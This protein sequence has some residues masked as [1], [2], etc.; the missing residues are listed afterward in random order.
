MV[1]LTDNRDLTIPVYHGRKA[2]EQDNQMCRS[3]H[4]EEESKS[5][6]A[7][8]Y[9]GKKCCCTNLSNI[10]VSSDFTVYIFMH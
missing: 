5:K 6:Q 4:S 9:H 8:L 10:A 1:R 3:F 2:T 7:S